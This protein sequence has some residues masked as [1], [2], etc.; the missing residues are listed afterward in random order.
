MVH[1]PNQRHHPQ[2]RH[3]HPSPLF[4]GCSSLTSIT[5]PNSVTNIGFLAFGGCTSLTS[6][7]I[8]NSVTSIGDP[9]VPSLHQ[10]DQRH[11]SQQRHQHRDSMRSMTAPA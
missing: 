3:E 8:P 4:E 5:I 2:Q 1:E 11:D 9:C 7:T 10:P 6:V